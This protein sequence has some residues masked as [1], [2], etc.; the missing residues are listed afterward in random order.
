MLKPWSFCQLSLI[1][2]QQWQVSWTN[3]EKPTVRNTLMLGIQI[4]STP[5]TLSIFGEVEYE[6]K[7]SLF[8]YSS[9]ICLCIANQGPLTP[10][11]RKNISLVWTSAFGPLRERSCVCKVKSKIPSVSDLT[12][13]RPSHETT[14]TCLWYTRSPI[15]CVRNHR[16]YFCYGHKDKS[17]L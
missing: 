12:R 5:S 3:T 10:G 6:R 15:V 11:A 17:Q 13:D 9:Y 7:T 8:T 16:C 4:A 14:L 2:L 1:L